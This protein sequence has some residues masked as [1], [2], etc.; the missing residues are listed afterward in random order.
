MNDSFKNWC[1][2]IGGTILFFSFLVLLWLGLDSLR[3]RI[4]PP[5][6]YKE[7]SNPKIE[8]ELVLEHE[9]IKVFRFHDGVRYVYF[10]D[11]RGKTVWNE[12]HT[13]GK[14]T[15]TEQHSVETAQ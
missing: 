7:S 6:S 1:L 14:V 3:P 5:Q 12:T 13:T 11:A 15:L 10:I 8:V 2:W 4:Q 9:G